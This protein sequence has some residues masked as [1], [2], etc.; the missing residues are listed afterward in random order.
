MSESTNQEEKWIKCSLEPGMLPDEYAVEIETVNAGR[1]SL[2]AHKDKV[3]TD[4][5]L[6]RVT[7]LDDSGD[8]PLV[9][10]P[11]PP[12]EITSQNVRVNRDHTQGDK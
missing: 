2:F 3:D 9:R 11:A 12:F 6:V 1:V 4:R 10:L 7:L 5:G 8:A